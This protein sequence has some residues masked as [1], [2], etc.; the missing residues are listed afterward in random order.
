MDVR[1]R[2][3]WRM[4][5]L[6]CLVALASLTVMAFTAE[7]QP[8]PP[9]GPTDTP[10]APP[11]PEPPAPVPQ[12]DEVKEGPPVKYLGQAAQPTGPMPSKF[13]LGECAVVVRP[14]SLGLHEEATFGAAFVRGV[15]LGEQVRVLEGPIGSDTLWW[16]KFKAADGKVGWGVGDYADPSKGPCVSAGLSIFDLGKIPAT[17]AG[18]WILPGLALAVLLIGVA[19]ARRRTA[20]AVVRKD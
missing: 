19:V 9:P 16:W 7:A 15:P 11:T 6:A 12:P 18:G 4:V 13:K 10:S 17:G 5:L 20:R 1:L 3:A 2:F 8:P 14:P